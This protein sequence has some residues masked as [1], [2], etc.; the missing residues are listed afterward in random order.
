MDVVKE[1]LLQKN[2]VKTFESHTQSRTVTAEAE[3]VQ[4]EALWT[5]TAEAAH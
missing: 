5:L 3:R 4:T 2:S 1:N